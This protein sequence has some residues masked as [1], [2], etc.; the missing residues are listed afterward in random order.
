MF[1]YIQWCMQVKWKICKAHEE[2]VC[3]MQRGRFTILCSYELHQT[4]THIM[5]NLKKKYDAD[6]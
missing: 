4:H 5:H 3:E 2:Y 6:A 1:I